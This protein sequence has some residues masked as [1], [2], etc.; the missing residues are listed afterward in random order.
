MCI[1]AYENWSLQ[2]LAECKQLA[3]QRP[4]VGPVGISC[5]YRGKRL[6]TVGGNYFNRPLSETFDDFIIWHLRQ[7][8]GDD[9]FSSHRSLPSNEQHIVMQWGLAMGEERERVF[10]AAPETVQVAS[11]QPTGDVQALLTLAYDVY[12]LCLIN[13]LPERI[14]DRVRNVNEFQ[15]VRYEIALAAS[16]TRA[17]F[18]ISW[19]ESNETHAEFTAS[20]A[21]ETIIVEAKSRHRP[22]VLHVSGNC[23]DF[24]CLIADI[25]S[26]YRRALEKPTGGLPYLIGID[27]NLPLTPERVEGF[28]NWVRDV[29]ELMDRSPQPTQERPAKEFFLAL[30]NFSWHYSGQQPAPAHEV[31]YLAPEWASAVPVNRQTIIA[32]FQAFNCYCIR[33][34]GI[35]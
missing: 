2:E 34:E 24:S 4:Y 25:G 23:P 29:F 17:G 16:L 33:P 5:I 12:C 7:A 26:L 19:L 11:S 1:D 6:R 15:G 22:G 18:R 13:Q 8:L 21:E 35:W 3:N 14:L 10:A 28:D 9:W 20:L 30:T 31:N 32:L 27:V